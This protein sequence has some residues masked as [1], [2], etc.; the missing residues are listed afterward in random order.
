M[1]EQPRGAD[2][3]DAGNSAGFAKI[4]VAVIVAV[5]VCAAAGL[6]VYFTVLAPRLKAAES[7]AAETQ[8]TNDAIP[9]T[10]AYVD[11]PEA[12]AAAVAVEPNEKTSVLTY[13]V[14]IICENAETKETVEKN[15]QLFVA[16][17]SDLHRNK[18]K[19]D[20]EDP[21]FQKSLLKQAL[22]EGNSLLRRLQKEPNPEIKIFQMLY[23]KYAVFTMP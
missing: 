15:K 13:S 19:K 14:S 11:L 16:M 8:P 9:E 12:Q 23:L 2:S 10:A 4:L 18:T 3:G 5:V 17:L 7:K 6:G 1:T 21:E 22:E 20:L